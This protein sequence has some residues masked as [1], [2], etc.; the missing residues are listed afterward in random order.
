MAVENKAFMGKSPGNIGLVSITSSPSAANGDPSGGSII[1][2][3]GRD[4][5][6]YMW[7]PYYHLQGG[8]VLDEFNDIG[9]DEIGGQGILED[10]VLYVR[11]TPPKPQ[12]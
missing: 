6:V 11:I 1:L 8:G 7:D 10:D 4:G 5:D 12:S 9:E 2:G 3:V